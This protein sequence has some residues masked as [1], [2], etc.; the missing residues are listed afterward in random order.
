MANKEYVWEV[1]VRL[2]HWVNVLSIL[3]L[4]ITGFYI[5]NPY[6]LASSETSMIMGSM[7]FIHFV[8]GYLLAVGLFVRIYWWFAG[9]K[10]ARLDQ[11]LPMSDERCK[12]LTGTTQFYCFMKNDMP[13]YAGHTGLAGITY[14]ALFVLFIVEIQT[15]FGLYAQS[16]DGGIFWT[17]MGG[18]LVPAGSSGSGVR[19]VHHLIM[20]CVIVYLIAHIYIVIHNHLIEKNGLL[21]SIFNGY[22][23][24]GDK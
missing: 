16:H 24:M 11:F 18:W 3:A 23:T 2:T 7:R 1:P 13:H 20:W 14:F 19:L 12:N 6:I 22:K 9:N 15:G 17:L 5:A 8:S 21:M 4:I 10:Y